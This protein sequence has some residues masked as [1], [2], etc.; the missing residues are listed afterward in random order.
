MQ[1]NL[2]FL[3]R[4][5]VILNLMFLIQNS[6]SHATSSEKL[7]AL[8][9]GNSANQNTPTLPNPR[10][11]SMEIGKVL[12]RLGFDVDVQVDLTKHHLDKALRQFGDRL[13]G[14]QVAVFY[15]AGHGIQVVPEPII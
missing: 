9:I 8:V 10:N 11:D 3:L 14:A 5:L 2:P 1:R 6:P 4:L 12:K 7:V 13:E 15:Y